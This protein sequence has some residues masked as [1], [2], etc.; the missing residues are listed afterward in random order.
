MHLIYKPLFE[1][2]HLNR[3][4]IKKHILIVETSFNLPPSCTTVVRVI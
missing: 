2:A 4:Q 1:N 3:T